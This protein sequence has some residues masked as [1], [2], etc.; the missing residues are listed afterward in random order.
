MRTGLR[1]IVRS[2]LALV[3]GLWRPTVSPTP[4]GTAPQPG[5]APQETR[6]A[7][8]ASLRPADLP[9]VGLD[10]DS[11][12]IVAGRSHASAPDTLSGEVAGVTQAALPNQAP[13][14]EPNAPAEVHDGTSD[15]SLPGVSA[16]PAPSIEPRPPRPPDTPNDDAETGHLDARDRG[17]L[18]APAAVPVPV[19]PTP[20]PP[21]PAPAESAPAP[22]EPVPAPRRPR[23]TRPAGDKRTTPPRDIGGQRPSGTSAPATRKTR[24]YT[25]APELTVRQAGA[26]WEVVL[27]AASDDYQLE[28]VKHG[29][30]P[31]PAS[32]RECSIPSL[33][34]SLTV[35]FGRDKPLEL[36]LAGDR[37]MVFKLGVDWSGTG[38]RV[39]AI[40]L[41]HFIVIAPRDWSRTGRVPVEPEDCTD[42]GFHAHYFYR[43]RGDTTEVGGFN[44]YRR[45]LTRAAAVLDGNTIFDD[46]NEGD[47]FGGPE[48]PKLTAPGAV[49]AR[50]GEEG[51]KGWGKNFKLNEPLNKVLGGR[52]GRFFVRVYDV[53]SKLLDSCEFRYLRSLREICINGDPYTNDGILAPAATGHAPADV[54]FVSMGGVSR[55]NPTI[56]STRTIVV[57]G[58]DHVL[59][60]PHPD[61]D[62]VS[63]TLASEG[64]SV[65][66]VL[67]LPRIWWRMERDGA[68]GDLWVDRPIEL[69]RGEFAKHAMQ[70]AAIRVRLPRTVRAAVLG[71]DDD[72]QKR[73]P[74]SREDGGRYVH[75]CV[76]L[77]DF[78]FHPQILEALVEDVSLNLECRGTGLA[79]VR[80]PRDPSPEI[81]SFTCEPSTVENGDPVT[82][83]WETLNA[84]AVAIEPDVGVVAK[85]GSVEIKPR[86][87]TAYTL[88]LTGPG[89]AE[90]T[91][92]ITAT[93]SRVTTISLACSDDAGVAYVQGG[94]GGRRRGKGFSRGEIQAAGVSRRTAMVCQ[95]RSDGRRRTTH[96][97]NVAA[98][99]RAIDA[100]HR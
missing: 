28:E 24:Q 7:D 3:R 80:V 26:I 29:G 97:A 71:F 49:W 81:V 40:T 55:F 41:G 4:S 53:E 75:L 9:T 38:R 83:T 43:E 45:P 85:T 15:G 69:T 17:L 57:E 6:T 64:G 21:E 19:E 78:A 8:A 12:E 35:A 77:T 31:L 42:S 44:E 46:S 79:L 66:V 90:V 73:Y 16:P 88:K 37:P 74:T 58:G 51:K 25:P 93:V 5:V 50:V 65:D 62:S 87:T 92:T 20:E 47:L 70:D 2:V 61:A 99:R 98:I 84:I 32:H 86:G 39:S 76:P 10:D 23:A 59:V 30:A 22:A 60:D 11:S 54:R 1:Q 94:C 27:V 68:D 13:K 82:L 14:I 72:L 67:D 33:I 89:L 18:L 100:Q 96:P 56:H 36:P 34:G 95:L 52:Q 48:A 63:C 91:K